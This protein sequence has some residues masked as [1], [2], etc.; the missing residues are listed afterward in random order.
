MTVNLKPIFNN[1]SFKEDFTM[2][3][4]EEDS[5]QLKEVM[6]ILS[7][8][9]FNKDQALRKYT[10]KF[11]GQTV[12][13]FKVPKE[14]LKQSYER[15]DL[16]IKKALEFTKERIE[17]YERKIKY[18]NKDLGEF[19]YLYYPLEKVGFYVPGGKALYPSTVLM[20][21]VAAQVA[22]VSEIYVVTPT[23]SKNNITFAT[24]YIC[25]VENVYT[26][27]GAQAIA[28]L[29]YGTET[30]PAVDKIVGPGNSY[31]AAAK[32]LVFGEVGIDS[33]AGPSE[34]LIY[35]DESANL[36]AVVL[37]LFAQAEHDPQAKT[38]LLSE[39]EELL[40]EIRDLLLQRIS[41]QVRKNII[42]ESIENYHYSITDN[43]GE[44]IDLINYIAPEHV[45]I[46]HDA[47]E[48]IISQIRFAGAIFQG[49]FSPEAIGD[50]VAGPSHVLPTNRNARYSH[51]LNVNDFMTSHAVIDI[52][53]ETF[54]DIVDPGICI[55][56]EEGLFAHADSLKIRKTD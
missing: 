1:Q 8:V 38:Y 36:E 35:V 53:K 15:L 10:S 23:F 47:A 33:I 25:G 7:D 43:R 44:L 16:K 21:I 48:S 2:N 46:Q 14:Y 11:D 26:L 40:K 5:Y 29:A 3:R 9:R 17:D 52:S 39:S 50:Y 54:E 13:D 51:G 49:D 12:D 34:I 56:E 42:S 6:Q 18:S 4:I 32:R 55:A 41:E 24:L 27:G 22:G 37:D 28:A 20:S 30:I 45:S 31:V 19:Q